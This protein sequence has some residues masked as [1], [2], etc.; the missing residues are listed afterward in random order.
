LTLPNVG[1]GGWQVVVA[2][3]A[4]NFYGLNLLKWQKM[5]TVWGG[6]ISLEFECCLLS[7]RCPSSHSRL[8]RFVFDSKALGKSQE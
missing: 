7:T 6:G 4:A 5:L 2:N 1:E 8:R 3:F